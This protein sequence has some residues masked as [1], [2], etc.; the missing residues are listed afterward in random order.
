VRR[1]FFAAFPIFGFFEGKYEIIA[2]GD[3]T[4]HAR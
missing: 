2:F 1:S 4:L 3:V